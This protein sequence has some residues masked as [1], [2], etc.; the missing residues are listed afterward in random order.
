MWVCVGMNIDSSVTVV[1][2]HMGAVVRK[3]KMCLDLL[4]STLKSK[5]NHGSNSVQNVPKQI[6]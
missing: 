3:R 5:I 6:S 2:K 1:G 4:F